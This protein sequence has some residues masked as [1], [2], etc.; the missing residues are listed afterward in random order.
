MTPTSVFPSQLRLRWRL[1]LVGLCASV[2]CRR[3]DDCKLFDTCPSSLLERA[4]EMAEE[5]GAQAK[6]CR[7]CLNEHCRETA[8]SCS[9]S[10]ECNFTSRCML[11]G[12]PS[13]YQACMLDLYEGGLTF[14]R[15]KRFPW[16]GDENAG[17]FGKCLHDHCR[18]ACIGDPFACGETFREYDALRIKVAVRSYPF[19]ERLEGLALKACQD[20]EGPHATLEEE[21]RNCT[22]WQVT[23]R[24]GIASFDEALENEKLRDISAEGLYFEIEGQEGLFPRTFYYPGRL[25]E[26]D[27]Q[28]LAIYVVNEQIIKAANGKLQRGYTVLQ[29]AAQSLILTDSC[30]WEE[31]SVPGLTVK[32][33]GA[34][35]VPE[36]YTLDELCDGGGCTSC[37]WYATDEFPDPHAEQT[38]GTGAG[39]V[40]L[41]PGFYAIRVE[42]GGELVSRRPMLRMEAGAMTIARTWPL[43][44]GRR[45]TH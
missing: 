14:G 10:F 7:E 37:V 26:S 13:A 11:T 39:V 16:E 30:V 33:E 36:C 18:T 3:P 28:L 44:A 5:V 17:I 25:G 29:D 1:L 15:E 34:P 24:W 21:G 8:L 19:Y 27:L 41:A 12:S 35:L 6:T 40:G 42:R 38:D 43:D 31:I 45:R 20:I 2:A 22:D 32:V 9:L 4:E 23:D